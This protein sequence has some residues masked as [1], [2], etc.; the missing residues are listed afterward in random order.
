MHIDLSQ[1]PELV[2]GGTG[3]VR[4]QDGSLSFQR[5]TRGLYR[6]IQDDPPAEFWDYMI[7]CAAGIRLV[8][9]TDA[10]E[11]KME[12]EYGKPLDTPLYLGETDVSIDGADFVTF[13]APAFGGDGNGCRFRFACDLGN[14]GKDKTVEIFLSNQIPFK[15][16]AFDLNTEHAPIPVTYKKSILFLG[17]SITQGY[18]D[19]PAGCYASRY[20]AFRHADFHNTGV[21][22]AS[23]RDGI[24]PAAM[25]YPWDE[26]FI[27]FGTNDSGWRDPE[28][29]KK[30]MLNLL[31]VVTRRENA[32]IRIITPIPLL[33]DE[34]HAQKMDAFRQA[35]HEVAEKYP[36]V[37]VIDGPAMIPA[38]NRYFA[39]G[40]HPNAEGMKLYAQNL[41]KV[42]S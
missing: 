12:L 9:Q 10:D 42:L 23:L 36:Q 28:D 22:G 4:N 2:R 38:D 24:G 1:H 5:L 8:F 41:I 13:R 31:E 6:V 40:C 35:I 30:S 29:F 20:A 33:C 34:L 14:P 16:L 15:L 39:D 32:K 27:A 19:T 17:D 7:D 25:E 37:T 26:L 3:V 18:F 21:G 11:F